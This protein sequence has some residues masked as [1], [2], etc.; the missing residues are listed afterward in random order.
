MAYLFY[1]L[2]IFLASFFIAA[3]LV[4]RSKVLKSEFNHRTVNIALRYTQS[5]RTGGFWKFMYWAAPV[6]VFLFSSLWGGLALILA[7]FAG[8]SFNKA[9][10]RCTP[11]VQSAPAPQGDVAIERLLEEQRL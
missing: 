4:G 11:Q 5:L 2:L 6:G 3:S 8:L 1:L 10:L 9:W 7:A